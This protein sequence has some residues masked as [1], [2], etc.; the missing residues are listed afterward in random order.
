[1]ANF[2][3]ASLAALSLP[4]GAARAATAP[5]YDQMTGIGAMRATTF[6]TLLPH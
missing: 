4:S 6:A 1:M 3:P 5:G 2:T